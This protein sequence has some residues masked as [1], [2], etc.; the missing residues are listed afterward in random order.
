MSVF[1]RRPPPSAFLEISAIRLPNPSLRRTE[2]VRPPSASVRLGKFFKRPLS[3]SVLEADKGG[4][5]PSAFREFEPSAVR[6]R[7]FRIGQASAFARS[8][9]YNPSVRRPSQKF[10]A[11][12]AI[13]SLDPRSDI[14]RSMES[15]VENEKVRLRFNDHENQIRS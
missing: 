15:I 10:W 14:Q 3:E 13:P 7:P 1:V 2:W 5:H 12:T 9:R 4:P 6:I 8:R 11:R